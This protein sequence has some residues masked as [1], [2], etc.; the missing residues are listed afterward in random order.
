MGKEEHQSMASVRLHQKGRITLNRRQF[1]TVSAMAT[2]SGALMSATGHSDLCNDFDIKITPSSVSLDIKDNPLRITERC[3][4]MPQKNT[5]FARQLWDFEF[6]QRIESSIDRSA[7]D[8][9]RKN[10]GWRQ[11]DEALN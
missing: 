7:R 1:M 2:A 3:K 11:L 8:E 4:R 6:A 9:L 5:I 10:K